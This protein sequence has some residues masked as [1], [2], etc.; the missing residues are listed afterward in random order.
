MAYTPLTEVEYNKALESGYSHDEIVS[1]EK[2]R[3]I[4]ESSSQ[5]ENK[6]KTQ[7][8]MATQ[9]IGYLK[10]HP[11]KAN[12]EPSSKTITGKSLEDYTNQIAQAPGMGQS[13]TAPYDKN[14]GSVQPVSLLLNMIGQ[15]GDIA[16]TPATYEAG[17]ILKGTGQVLGK[18]GKY[19][20]DIVS[21]AK[22]S[23]ITDEVAPKAFSVYKNN[24]E[25][26]TPE[27]ESYA[28]TDLAVPEEAIKTIKSNGVNNIDVLSNQ[29]GGSTD[30][31]YQ[32]IQKGIEKK[33]QE[34]E[35]AY[36]KAFNKMPDSSLIH[37]DKTKRAMGEMLREYGYID[38]KNKETIMAI[39]DTIENSPLKRI[40]GFYKALNPNTAE[41]VTALNPS[42]W[43]LFR[44]N[45]SRLSRQDK[46]LS[47]KITGILD[48]L[49]ADAEKAGLKGITSARNLARANFQ[50]E[51]NILNSSLI[52]ERRLDNYF[53][54]QESDK[55]QLKSIEDFI[56][57]PFINDLKG[58]TAG[59][60][61][62]NIRE[63]KTI[64]SFVND[65]NS[66]KD[67]SKTNF[68]MNKYSKILGKENAR[69]IF[70][71]V[72]TNRK[73]GVAKKVAGWGVGVTAT[74]EIGRRII[75][76]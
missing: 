32:K 73:L 57:T 75:P 42:Q 18:A 47:N 29:Y 68:L 24:V 3:K 45:L 2:Q 59:K 65:L 69:T 33:S 14:L 53:K 64:E 34:V 13:T 26:F 8:S 49:H 38:S 1:L 74:E 51:E 62:T 10:E 21:K 66:A 60:Y 15:A 50:A 36:S 11:F 25:K 61:L 7:E 23:Y 27:I 76:H 54:L 63:G 35:E 17:P 48:S 40:L 67:R 31:I 72:I 39:N 4:D 9:G 46:S 6:P 12:F 71:E 22:A 56:K 37:V 52:K 20:G 43:N 55:R 44:N 16:T 28:K 70:N 41:G 30:P 58:I 5:K 19:I